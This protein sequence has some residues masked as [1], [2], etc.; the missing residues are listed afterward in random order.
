[1]RILIAGATGAIGRPLIAALREHGHTV[2]ALARS[3]A[4][5]RTVTALGA[6][7]V[8]ADVLDPAAV[9]TAIMQ[10][11]PAAV[12]NELTSLPRRYTA[13]EMA[14]AAERDRQVRIE[15]NRN[16]LAVLPEAGVSRYLLQ[17]SGFWYAPGA[18]LAAE[19]EAFAFAASPAVAAGSRRYAELEQ[20]A[21]T[22]A[23]VEFIALRYGFFYG[24]G[25]WFDSAGDMGEQV[26]RQQVPV[27]GDGQGVWSWVHI[28]DAAAA[29]A[30]ALVCTPGVYNVVDDDASPQERWLPAFAHAVGAP[31]PPRVSET[32]ALAASGP[33]A[34]YYATRL[35]GAANAKARRE[36]DFRPRRLEWLAW[37]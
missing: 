14:A 18:G 4:S 21:S 25:T 12:I 28:D 7:A 3:P 13:A 10:V 32:E 9:R 31:P 37:A 19:D 23:G 15:G 8:I 11:R 30:A 33:D 16:L 29:T 1:M 2:F 24:P 26:H 17:S 22:V 35:R 6:E 20:S 34:V 27:I 36:L 5:A